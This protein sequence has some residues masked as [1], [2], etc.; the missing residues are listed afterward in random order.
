[1][2]L[3]FINI[4]LFSSTVFSQSALELLEGSSD[5]T[6]EITITR[7]KAVLYSGLKTRINVNSNLVAKLGNGKTTK[8]YASEGTNTFSVSGFGFPGQSSVTFRVKA[9]ETYTLYVASR[10]SSFWAMMGGGALG[11]GTLWS[12]ALESSL[13]ETEGGGFRISLI[14]TSERRTKETNDNIKN[15]EGIESQLKELKDLFEKGLITEELYKEEQKRILQE[16]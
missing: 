15:D 13:N 5:K 8:F 11:V 2:K 9:G 6:A 14:D 16:K 7:E 12:S 1:M 3:I 10:K 4:L